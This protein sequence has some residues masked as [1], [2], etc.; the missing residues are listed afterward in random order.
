[1]RSFIAQL[2]R[3][4]GLAVPFAILLLGIVDASAWWNNDWGGRVK[5][6]IDPA[7]EGAEI[8]GEPGE[9]V[10]L[11]RLHP[12]VL[13]FEFVNQDGSD[14][15]F[16]AGD[17]KTPLAFHLEKF[18]PLMAEGF[19]WVRVPEISGKTDVWLYYGNSKPDAEGAPDP[20]KT[21]PD[22][23]RLVYHL[24]ERGTPRVIPRPR[25]PMPK[26]RKCH[27]RGDHRQRTA[28]VG[29][30]PVKIPGTPANAWG[31]GGELTIVLWVKLME[32][33]E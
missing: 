12:G 2:P 27:G 13:P 6:T 29:R 26:R 7:V 32:H 15:R 9:V 10:V 16:L 14:L 1:M 30:E 24:D 25:V 20:K 28:P 22:N 4:R 5:L 11:V 18:D 31:A 23:A 33:L 19:A 21:Y 17:D 3:A 8:Q